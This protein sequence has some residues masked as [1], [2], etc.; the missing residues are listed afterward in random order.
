MPAFISSPRT[1]RVIALLFGIAACSAPTQNTNVRPSAQTPARG[2]ATAAPTATTTVTPAATP[3]PVPGTLYVDPDRSLGPI[4]R[5][6]YGTNYG[7]WMGA[8]L[9]DVQR[10]AETAGFTFLRF[11]GGEW[12]DQQNLDHLQIDDY[13]A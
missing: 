5:L 11:P 7:P 4:S 6:V 8:F 12:G 10:Q 9:P 3:T 13:I 2:S 1:L